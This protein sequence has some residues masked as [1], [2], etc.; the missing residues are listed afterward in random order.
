MTT[1]Q[2]YYIAVV[3]KDYGSPVCADA[4]VQIDAPSG[5][6]ALA[7]EHGE[8]WMSVLAADGH[9]VATYELRVQRRQ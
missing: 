6:E 9:D 3:T 5:H 7:R 1:R 4:R 2:T 8:Q